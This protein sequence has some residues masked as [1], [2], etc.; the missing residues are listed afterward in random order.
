VR[1]VD[2]ADIRRSCRR[3]RRLFG[4]ESRPPAA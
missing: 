4:Y 2:V 1:S 3:L